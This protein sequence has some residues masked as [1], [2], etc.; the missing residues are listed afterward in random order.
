LIF[1]EENDIEASLS[2]ST[3][4]SDSDEDYCHESNTRTTRDAIMSFHGQCPLTRF[5]I[6]GL[7]NEHNVCLCLSGNRIPNHHLVTHFRR[8][9]H[10][11]LSLSYE[12]TKAMINK[13]N[14]LTTC[15]FRSD[16]HIIDKRFYVIRCPL[17]RMKLSSCKKKFYKD[18]LRTHLL[19]VHRLTSKTT[20]QIVG[21]INA[22]GDLT[23]LDFDEDEFQ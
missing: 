22:Q 3:S 20:N 5:G 4:D 21:T 15:I 10:L 14:P 1:S 18:S 6:F 8:Y 7:N 9:H 11:T 2:S 16:M 19:R 23:K 12:L 13:L 17:K